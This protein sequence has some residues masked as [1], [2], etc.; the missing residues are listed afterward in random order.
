MKKITCILIVLMSVLLTCTVQAAEVD[1]HEG[2]IAP[3]Y[4]G[5]GNMSADLSIT[6][7]GSRGPEGQ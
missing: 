7:K 3:S 2:E 6:G 5:L 1:K 4:V